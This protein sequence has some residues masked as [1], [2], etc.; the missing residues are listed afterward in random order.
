[1]ATKDYVKRPRA[2]NKKQAQKRKAQG[3]ERPNWLK[4]ILALS[5]V[6][7]FAYGLYQ[8]QSAGVDDAGIANEIENPTDSAGDGSI[9]LGDKVLS[10]VEIE[11]RNSALE[12]VD[13]SPLPVL[14]EED[15][16]YI[17]SLPDFSVEVD[18]T[19]PKV[20]DRPVI[21]QCGSFKTPENADE[22]RAMIALQGLESR[23]LT[24]EGRNG[25][26]YRVVLGPYERKREAERHR[27][28]LRLANINGC[29]IW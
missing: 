2:N 24:S 25:L 14:Q 6:G 16:E 21:M 9:E 17:D 15:W 28:Q 5:V 4:I 18:A 1:M 8:L 22:M 20:S 12:K 29:K 13:L 11:Q 3:E 26:W 10:N 19:G 23:M 7:V 27:H